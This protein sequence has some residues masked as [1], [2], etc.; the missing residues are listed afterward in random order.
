M[1]E[2]E[3]LF[4]FTVGAFII[5][6]DFV[7]LHDKKKNENVETRFSF[8]SYLRENLESFPFF[9]NFDIASLCCATFVF[10]SLHRP[11]FKLASLV[12]YSKPL[13]F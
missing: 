7:S 2:G 10:S 3:T 8:K 5:Y 12:S 1:E 6:L 4:F 13:A 9:C 11:T